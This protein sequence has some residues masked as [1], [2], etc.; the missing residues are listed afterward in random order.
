MSED[1]NLNDLLAG[2][3]A[4]QEQLN[5]LQ[6]QTFTG[7]AGGD[8]VEIQ[9]TGD[10]NLTSVKIKPEAVDMDDLDG[11][12]DLIIAAWRDA[13]EQLKAQM[14]Q[15]MPAMPDLSQFGF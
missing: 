10:G 4:M 9:V 5:S 8:L 13:S 3:Q 15:A 14:N 7:T 11:L 12:G 6:S 1:F 2:A